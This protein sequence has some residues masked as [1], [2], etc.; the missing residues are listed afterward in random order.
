MKN[1]DD[2]L[3]II[4]LCSHL[5]NNNLDVKPLSL[6]EWNSLA[7]LIANSKIQRPGNL[8]KMDLKEIKSELMY[9]DKEI[10]RLKKLLDRA[11]ILTFVLEEMWTK[12]INIV[13]RADEEYPK[14]IKERL[15]H[16]A[17][18]LLYYC[19]DINL[20][21]EK[22]IA[23][24][25]SRDIDDYAFE[26]TKKLAKKATLEGLAIYSG[27]SRGVDSISE[28][29]VLNNGGVVISFLADSLENKIKKREI[30]EKIQAKKLLLLSA[31][32]PKSGFTVANAMNR[33]KFVYAMSEG[34]FVISADYNKG[35]TW[36]GAIDNINNSWVKIFVRQDEKLKGNQE[37]IKRGAV[38]LKN[39]ENI[40]EILINTE[41]IK[42]NEL[43]SQLNFFPKLNECNEN[44]KIEKVN[45][46]NTFVKPFNDTLINIG[47]LDLYNH[48]LQVLI[49]ILQ[50]EKNID[51]I[52][53]I[54]N[55]DKKQIRIWVNRAVEEGMVRKLNKPLRYVS[56]E[57]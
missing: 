38:A 30:R 48:I 24:V 13:T 29:E 46:T 15:K 51:E 28:I 7:R 8:L 4:L 23:I 42:V 53:Q 17:P 37:L 35:G 25:G 21:N 26:F 44:S 56:I 5:A 45:T 6:G 47:N 20:S 32:N 2:R 18:P 11:G 27:G 31:V 1:N 52:C 40:N 10:E 55:T 54:T 50:E 57:K 12:G 43:G 34:A 41:I 16:L 33:N 9:T 19:G 36:A 39:I 22:G 49:N 3:A 14:K